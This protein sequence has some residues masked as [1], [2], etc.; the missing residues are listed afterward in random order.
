MANIDYNTIIS[1]FDNK[2]TL[3]QWLKNVDKALK[4]MLE[5]YDSKA[6]ARDLEALQE[7]VT[8]IIADVESLQENTATKGDV[9]HYQ[10]CVAM[11]IDPLTNISGRVLSAYEATQ[12]SIA[13]HD[14]IQITKGGNVLNDKQAKAY[15]RY[16]CGSEYVPT[17][18]YN[19]PSFSYFI[20]SD[21]VIYKPQY[22]PAYGIALFYVATLPSTQDISDLDERVTALENAPAG[23]GFYKHTLS[24]LT[25][26]MD[27]PSYIIDGDATPI[28]S[29]NF[30][31]R[32][33]NAFVV[34]SETRQPFTNYCSQNGETTTAMSWQSGA[35]AFSS[36]T[37]DFQNVSDSVTAL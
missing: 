7:Q 23:G 19:E 4:E 3:L 17:Y 11:V 16:M 14:A 1:N 28:T 21:L 35:N 31:S 12:T 13:G 8:G 18:E 34:Q 26:T 25:S 2:L 15:L 22:D 5:A 29:S 9:P 33:Q 27:K 37:I 24:G 20:T 32:M 6:D 30:I 10:A 36:V